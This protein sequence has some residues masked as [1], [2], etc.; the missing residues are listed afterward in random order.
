MARKDEDTE[1]LEDGSIYFIYRPKKGAEEVEDLSDVQRFFVV[2]S[3]RGKKR[4]RRL[5]LG[6]KKM[7]RIDAHQRHWGFVDQVAQS[8]TT[9]ERDLQGKSGA[10]AG[11]RPEEPARPAGEG[12][13]LILR[14]GNHTHL[15]Y[16]LQLPSEPGEAQKELHI[17]PEGSYVLSV[18]NPQKPS[19]KEAGLPSQR[20]ADLPRRLEEVF[21]DRKFAP[22]DPPDFLDYEGMEL[23]LVGARE[24]AE[25]ELD[26]DLPHGCEDPDQAGIF[27][28][29]HMIKSRHPIEPLTKGEWT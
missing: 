3:P 24:D 29:L 17:E 4:L 25:A 16:S 10:E 9:V 18:K 26:V 22:A 21:H 23:L 2:L 6:R 1:I 11:G 27:R 5:V 14:H 28:E 7:A 12:H 13:Y 20:K 19:P 8:G 15:A